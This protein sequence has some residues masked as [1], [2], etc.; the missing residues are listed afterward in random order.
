MRYQPWKYSSASLIDNSECCFLAFG[1]R[2]R[3]GCFD[4]GE[5]AWIR[6]C[7]LQV[8]HEVVVESDAHYLQTYFSAF[9]FINALSRLM[10]AFS[11]FLTRNRLGWPG[12]FGSSTGLGRLLLPKQIIRAASVVLAS[13]D[14]F[15]TFALSSARIRFERLS[16]QTA[17]MLNNGQRDANGV[18]VRRSTSQVTILVRLLSAL[19]RVYV[20]SADNC[21]WHIKQ[22][23]PIV[24]HRRIRVNI[25]R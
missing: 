25:D 23:L 7:L 18:A 12:L 9:L 6:F 3:G 15:L 13:I 1:F 16:V 21:R 14:D 8:K 5:S 11:A 22:R 2:W 20:Y 4:T 24:T 17:L 19:T 10:L